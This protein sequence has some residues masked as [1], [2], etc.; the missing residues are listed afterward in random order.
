MFLWVTGF[1]LGWSLT[2]TSHADIMYWSGGV[3]I[4]F[5]SI[6][7]WKS[8]HKL[9]IWGYLL[10]FIGV[11]F[12]FTDSF[13]MKTGMD[14]QSYLGDLVAFIGAG[15]S[16]I[17]TYYNKKHKLDLHPM[18]S[19]TQMFILCWIHQ[20]IFFPFLSNSNEKFFTLDLEYGVFG[21]INDSYAFFLVICINAPITGVIGNIGY[22][23]AFKY[24][25]I[26]II[27]G[28]ML[29]EPFT[30]QIAAILLGQDK[31]PGLKTI[32]GCCI[33]TIGFL[34]SGLGAKLISDEG[35]V[36]KIDEPNSKYL[37]CS[38]REN[39]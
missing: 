31:I 29:I 28:V 15:A 3:F 35:V 21:W 27:A 6:V 18:V 10:Y 13:A 16:A 14:R 33:I 30:A 9:E 26:Q 36:Q 5:A 22:Y 7:T 38:K 11:Y 23:S 20:F 1:I 17:F 12:M 4:F 37:E 8:V 24:F 32:M 39:L 19:L 25:P 34:L 2:L